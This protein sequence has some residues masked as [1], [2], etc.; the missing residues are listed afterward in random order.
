MRSLR[1]SAARTTDRAATRMTDTHTSFDNPKQTL[2]WPR[3]AGTSFAI[4]LH[5]VV[6][7]TLMAPVTSQK[8]ADKEDEVTLVNFIEPPPA[9]AAAAA[10][11]EGTA[12]DD[13]PA[14]S[15]RRSRPTFRRRRKNRRWSTTIRARSHVQAPPPAPPAPPSPRLP[16]SVAPSIPPVARSI[17]RCIRRKNSAAASPAQSY[18]FSAMTSAALSPTSR[19][20]QSSGNRNLDRAAV[21]AAKRWK[22]NPGHARRGT[23]G[24]SGEVPVAFTL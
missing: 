8:S 12:E 17:R 6:F 1:L 23:R 7:M 13:H 20:K 22:I 21:K 9:A 4:A 14:S 10:A 2:S 19:S 18:L 11:A 5:V 16:I 3:I 24:R 15:R